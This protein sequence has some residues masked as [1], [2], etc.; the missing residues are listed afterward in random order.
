M[1]TINPHRWYSWAEL[2]PK[3]K[4]DE[5]LIFWSKTKHWELMNSGAIPSI[6]L[7]CRKRVVLGASILAYVESLPT[8]LKEVA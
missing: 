1:K 6:Y 3:N 2:K 8:S 7:S 5:H 4:P